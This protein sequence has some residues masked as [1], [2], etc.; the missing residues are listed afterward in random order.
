MKK[1]LIALGML[2]AT[3]AH[4]D[5]VVGPDV[6]PKTARDWTD[7]VKATH[8]RGDSIVDVIQGNGGYDS[9]HKHKRRS[10]I[11][12]VSEN[13]DPMKGAEV[14]LFFHGL[15]GFHGF[16]K[17]EANQAKLMEFTENRNFILV[18]PEMPWSIN[19]STPTKRQGYAWRGSKYEDI[20]KFYDDVLRKI[21]SQYGWNYMFWV[22]KL[23]VVGHSAGGSAIARAARSGGLDKLNPHEI[24]FSDAGYGTWTDQAWNNH[25]KNRPDTRFVLLVRKWDRPHKHTMR[26]L[27]RFKKRPKNIILRVFDRRKWTHGRI[28]NRCMLTKTSEVPSE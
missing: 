18:L 17:R 9:R 25:V 13:F 21:E 11:I 7:A 23:T 10:T 16:E 24:I 22:K 6:Y 20:I 27:K 14:I 28:G 15:R 26:F 1:L 8:L 19:T 4:A 2:I 3:T 5:I 12:Y